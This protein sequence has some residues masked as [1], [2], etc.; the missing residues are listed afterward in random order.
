MRT[1]LAQS[2]LQV[3]AKREHTNCHFQ[4]T[5]DESWMF[6]AY[7]HRT[8]WVSSWDDVDGI[9]RLSHL[10]QKTMFTVFFNGTWEYEIVIPPD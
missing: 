3:L 9:E 5:G 7:D 2:M 10:H 1:E 8:R 6:H 4:F